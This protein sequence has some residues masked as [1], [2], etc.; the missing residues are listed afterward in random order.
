MLANALTIVTASAKSHF[1]HSCALAATSALTCRSLVD[2]SK[3]AHRVVLVCENTFTSA[4][5]NVDA[6]PKQLV[7][8]LISHLEEFQTCLLQSQISALVSDFT[9]PKFLTRGN[10]WPSTA[11]KSWQT[12]KEKGEHYLLKY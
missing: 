12:K 1:A 9:L 11:A 8:T 7:Q 5:K 10:L 3:C 4:L 6:K 2:A